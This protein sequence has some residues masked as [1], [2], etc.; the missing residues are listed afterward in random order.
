MRIL[1]YF[2]TNISSIAILSTIETFVKQGHQVYFLTLAEKGDMHI[3]AEKLGAQAFSYPIEKKNSLLF[4][5]KHAK[6]LIRFCKHHKIDVI[7][8]HLYET[9]LPCILAKPFLKSK[10]L[11]VRHNTDEGRL[12]NPTKADIVHFLINKTFPTIIAPSQ[13]VYNY[14]R[15]IEKVPEN[16]LVLIPYGYNFQ[17]YEEINKGGEAEAIREK[18]N[19][20]FLILSVARVAKVKRYDLMMKAVISLMESGFDAKWVCIGVGNLLE[21]YRQEVLE[22]NLSDKIYFLGFRRNTLDYMEAADVFLHLSVTEA[23]N[24]AIKEA[25]LKRLP[26][27]VCK[28]VGDFEEY[29][30]NGV[31][32]FLVDKDDPVPEASKILR[33]LYLNPNL[34][35]SIGENLRQTVLDRFSAE[36]VAPLYAELLNSLDEKSDFD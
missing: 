32:G 34:R 6:Y 35:K 7:F 11:Y 17:L 30:E 13:R 5:S 20:K 3:L 36:K 8:S 19:C 1:I 23:S 15:E 18:Y 29:L 31:N 10:I 12:Y 21:K 14:L 26:V 33:E 25:G 2:P 16:K 24:N 4:F 28:G 22:R 9:A 27:I